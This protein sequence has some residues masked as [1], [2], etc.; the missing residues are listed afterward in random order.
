[1]TTFAARTDAGRRGGENE[2]AIGW[3]PRGHLWFVADGMGG[4]VAGA[5]ASHIVKDTLIELADR[6]PPEAAVLKAHEAVVSRATENTAYSGMGST[7]VSAWIEN[8]VCR[9]VW[10]G[11]SRAYLWRRQEL[12]QLTR[13]HSFLEE[14]R[15]QQRLSDT[16]LH[17]H[18]D[19]HLVTQTL[20]LG[21][22]VPSTIETRVRAGD[23]I[24]LC[25]DGLTDELTDPEIASILRTTSTVQDGADALIR[26]A[27]DKGGRDNVSAVLVACEPADTAGT[28]GLSS[29]TLALLAA[30]GGIAAALVVASV[31]WYLYGKR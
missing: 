22:P 16:E 20:G 4:H 14:L 31:W 11:D 25:S 27:L 15:A 3:D 10:V 24:L 18:P 29:V 26:A 28:G 5:V 9:V 7:L 8:G 6:L 30:V 12:K 23:W 21:T 2:D 13:D 1:M 17:N 19:R